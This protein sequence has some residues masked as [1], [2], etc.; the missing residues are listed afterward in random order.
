MCQWLKPGS[1][2]R[3]TNQRSQEADSRNEPDYLGGPPSR[4]EP[5]PQ[6]ESSAT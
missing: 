4:N 6:I 2:P 1:Q 3:E 5:K